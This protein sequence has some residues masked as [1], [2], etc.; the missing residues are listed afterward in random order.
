MKETQKA[1]KAAAASIPQEEDVLELSADGS[2]DLSAAAV[3]SPGAV[4]SDVVK[5]STY[6]KASTDDVVEADGEAKEKEEEEDKTPPRKKF[7]LVFNR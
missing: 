3:S 5:P 1:K 6:P 7:Y 2:F 4:P